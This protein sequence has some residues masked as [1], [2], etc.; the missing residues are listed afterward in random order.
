MF[1]LHI[2]TIDLVLTLNLTFTPTLAQCSVVFYSLYHFVCIHTAKTKYNLIIIFLLK[3]AS[4][5]CLQA[6]VL[7]HSKHVFVVIST[8]VCEVHAAGLDVNVCVFVCLEHS[9]FQPQRNVSGFMEAVL[10]KALHSSAS[11][12]SHFISHFLSFSD[13][14]IFSTSSLSPISSISYHFTC[15]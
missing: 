3:N 12:A 6:S 9:I 13:A 2:I 4:R 8:E 11:Q 14:F 15:F 7:I 10:R 5:V 1:Q